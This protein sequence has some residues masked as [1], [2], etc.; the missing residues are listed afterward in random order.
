MFGHD[1]IPASAN[2]IP[3]LAGSSWWSYSPGQVVNHFGMTFR[4]TKDHMNS[5]TMDKTRQIGDLLA[6]NALEEALDSTTAPPAGQNFLNLVQ[7]RAITLPNGACAAF[8]A[9][10][11][12]P[13]PFDVDWKQIERGQL[14]YLSR[15][16]AASLSLLHLSLVGGFS[17]PKINKVLNGTGYLTHS[18]PRMV[19]ARLLETFSMVIAVMCDGRESFQWSGESMGGGL[20]ATIRVRLLHSFV[21][22]MLLKKKG[23]RAWNA[24]VNGAPINQADM[25]TT[26]LSFSINVIYGVAGLWC[27]MSPSERADYIQLWR[28]VCHYIGVLDEFN[29]HTS[30]EVAQAKLESYALHVIAPDSSSVLATHAVLMGVARQPPMFWGIKFHSALSRR[31]MGDSLSDALCLVSPGVVEHVKVYVLL[32]L[33]WMHRVVTTVIGSAARSRRVG[34][35]IKQHTLGLIKWNKGGGEFGGIEARERAGVE[36]IGVKG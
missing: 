28:V 6:D 3:H 4:V 8:L 12:E 21:R 17:A 23:E 19:Q 31:L 2:T 36:G 11:R 7:T 34:L 24:A 5:T 14:A 1:D 20:E 10:L 22:R 9:H 27:P 16:P 33:L 13:P 29:P 35:F 32:G 30:Y 26:G 15:A 25:A 18:D